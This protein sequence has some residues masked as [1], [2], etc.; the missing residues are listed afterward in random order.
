MTVLVVDDDATVAEFCRRALSDA[1]HAVLIASSG[2]DALAALD[3]HEIDVVLSDVRMPG[4][5]G[6]ELLRHIS[7][8]NTGP[9]VVL[10]T[11]FA[12]IPSAV[13]AMRL[14][15]YDY[16]VKP[17]ASDQ[18]AAAIERLAEF[19]ALRTENLALRFQ[20]D[21]ER[22]IGGMIGG[23]PAIL[24]VFQ[25]L[26]RIAGKRQPVL[27]TGETGTGKELV[28]RA[29]HDLGPDRDRPFVAVDCGAL[30]A[31]IVESEIFGHVRGA[32]TG[33]VGDRPGLLASA[34]RGTLFLD[35]VGEL[36]LALQAKFFRVLQDREYR[37]LGGD[38]VRKFEG[39]VLAAT[40]RDL[41]AAVRAGTFRPELFFRLCVHAVHVPPLRARKGDIAV[42]IRHFI[43]KHGGDDVLAI[44]PDTLLELAAYHWPGNVRELENCIIGMLANCEGRVLETRDIPQSVRMALRQERPTARS[45]LEDA[46]RAA[47]AAALEESGGNIAETARRLGIAKATLYRKMSA[48]G[49][50]Q[51]NRGST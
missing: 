17:F 18:F 32:F 19:R 30:S 51:P 33:S 25:A 44:S 28:A 41:E 23:S 27:I 3:G 40:N 21:S 36:P 48:Y 29:I 5:D 43:R 9:D 1:G 4:M 11:G 15:A 37:P 42:L 45:P 7:R 26:P 12:S 38:A 13:E 6:L 14:G 8:G 46:E 10:M 39:R 49:L 16:L 24:A 2:E 50:T 20:L 31:D 22:G 47:I 34:A 35:E